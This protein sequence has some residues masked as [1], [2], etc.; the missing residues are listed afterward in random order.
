MS[1]RAVVMAML[2]LLSLLLSSSAWS[3]YAQNSVTFSAAASPFPPRT[4]QACAYDLSALPPSP[5]AAIY[6][7]GG[8]ANLTLF[9]DIWQ[10]APSS[11]SASA[12]FTATSDAAH[13]VPGTSGA[14]AAL[15]LNGDMLV[16][17]G[18]G[19]VVNNDVWL[20]T[21]SGTVWQQITANAPWS[22][23]SL[24]AYAVLPLTDVV[25]L[26]GGLLASNAP[27]GYNASDVWINVDGKGLA[28]TQQSATPP[29]GTVSA[30]AL[31]GLYDHTLV[32]TGGLRSGAAISDVWTS[33]DVGVTWTQQPTPAFGARAHHSMA[34][35]ADDLAYVLGGAGAGVSG[36]DVYVSNSKGAQWL[37]L[38]AAS[39]ATAL[40]N[41][42]AFVRAAST[43]KQLVLYGGDDGQGNAQGVLVGA[44]LTTL[45]AAS[46]TGI[47]LPANATNT[48]KPAL[49][50]L[51]AAA[52][53][54]SSGTAL[55]A[56]I[57]GNVN[58]S[59]GQ[60]SGNGGESRFIDVP[61]M[62]LATLL[63]MP[64]LLFL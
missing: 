19:G 16:F 52:A 44:V 6:V 23:R 33:S 51:S 37:S 11:A 7:I 21:T 1:L 5:S 10:S 46:S 56:S 4:L 57:V 14:G 35:D 20:S 38:S 12:S 48:A 59:S 34:V 9:N 45:Q 50:A 17:G 18:L 42:C 53:S 31:I 61:R 55:T 62:L 58:S 26:V 2:L 49:P 40:L 41:A 25:V 3:A 63:A 28:W 43:G 32:L 27:A 24:F 8:Y 15:L 39:S 54:S 22:S 47:A 29:F 30:A 36:L 60:G 64:A 13:P